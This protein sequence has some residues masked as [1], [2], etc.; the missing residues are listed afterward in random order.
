MPIIH[1]SGGRDQED[2]SSKPALA[3]SSRDLISEIPTQNR[4]GGVS[5]VIEHLDNL[6]GE[7]FILA[8]SFRGFSP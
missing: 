7:R 6:R 4:T 1:Y 5:Q 8:H 2:C 3:N